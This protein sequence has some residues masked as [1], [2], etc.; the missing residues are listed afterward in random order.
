[1][2]YQSCSMNGIKIVQSGGKITINGKEVKEVD[3][4]YH[5]TKEEFKRTYNWIDMMSA[6]SL[7]FAAGCMVCGFCISVL[8]P[9]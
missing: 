4:E 7:G 9:L 8:S 3:G 6:V 1:M 2:N 5:V